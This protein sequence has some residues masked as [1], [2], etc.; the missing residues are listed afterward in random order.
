L[1]FNRYHMTHY[2]LP[3]T[4]HRIPRYTLCALLIFTPLA[5]ASV[6]DWAVTTIHL[7]TLIALTAFLVEN[8]FSWK[9][10]WI[11]T[12]LDK[13]ILVLI[14]L[15]ILSTVFSVHK[16]TSIWSLILL[17]NYI[18]IFYLV[19]N[20][21]RNRSHFK[22]LIYTIVGV[23]AFLSI[24]GLIKLSGAN[25]FTWWEY[26]DIKQSSHRLSSTFG[27]PDHIAGYLEMVLPLV[28]GFFVLNY[29]PGIFVFIVYLGGL[30]LVA[31]VLTLSRGGWIGAFTSLA[32][33]SIVLLTN[34][35]F[36]RKKLLMCLIG[37]LLAVVLIILSSTAVV[38]R[39]RTLEQKDQIPHLASRMSR[40]RGT[41]AMI[42]DYPI[43]GTGPGTYAT[44]FTQ[45]QPPGYASRSFYAH[46][47]Y[48]HF[49]S[50]LGITFIALLVWMII[51]CYKK[52]FNKLKNP[53]R[54]V[55]GT[56][57]GALSGITAILIHSI[58]DFNLH[59]PANAILFTILSA[60]V[61]APVPADNERLLVQ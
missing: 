41:I 3:N 39:I 24:L 57:L 59:I 43:F 9:W 10:K 51:A 37:G 8:S 14:V 36:Q 30:L 49:T 45:Y 58:G 16:Y 56:T 26:T 28:L 61:V 27:N 42:K 1:I 52:G 40:W 46:N 55:R 44:I 21:V 50:E 17:F 54:L 31:L 20:T 15:S 53:S 19:I 60:V 12:P 34:R 5:R 32:F 25:P 33:M 22:Q 29:K 23:A 7:F 47:D 2:P 11:K 18:I 13:P 6:Q 48:L 38:E 4:P 35:Y